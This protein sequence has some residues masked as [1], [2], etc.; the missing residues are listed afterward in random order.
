MEILLN[1]LGISSP[2]YLEKIEKDETNKEVHLY[3]SIETSY[4]LGK[5][6]TRHSMRSRKWEHLN[7]F[8]YRCFIHCD[9]PLFEHKKTGK[10]ELMKVP[11]A[12][13][14]RRFTKKYEYKVLDYLLIVHNFKKVAKQLKISPQRVKG[15]YELYVNPAYEQHQVSACTRLGLD[16]TSTK[17]GHNY[18]SCFVDMDN[19]KIIDIQE[20]RSSET[21][22]MFSEQHPNPDAV[23]EISMDMSPAFIKGVDKYFPN[24]EKTFD[25]WHVWRLIFKHIE[26]LQKKRNISR[27]QREKLQLIIQEFKAF[28]QQKD[29][30]QANTQLAFIIDFIRDTFGE[31]NKLAKSLHRHFKGIVQFVRSQLTNGLLEGINSKIQVI[32]KQAR[33]FRYTDNFKKLILFVFGTIKPCLPTKFT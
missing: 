21:I 26:K 1:L 15:I 30:E 22:S 17:K 28:Y 12:L 7:W 10:T 25:C 13:P 5:N 9:L 11:F 18:L 14:N 27:L 16:E 24:A 32:R 29:W 8:E 33:G 20:G 23:K 31:K 3:L 6:W 19:Q 2:F 4:T